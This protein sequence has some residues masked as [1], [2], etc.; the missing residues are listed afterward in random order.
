MGLL[1]GG[2]ALFDKTQ[3]KKDVL[4]QTSLLAMMEKSTDS[5]EFMANMDGYLK[6]KNKEQTAIGEQLA[7]Q[8]SRLNLSD[9]YLSELPVEQGISQIKNLG[10][11]LG[12]GAIAIAEQAASAYMDTQVM[13][14]RDVTL[15]ARWGNV[16]R[17]GG[18]AISIAGGALA[19]SIVPRL[20]TLV[21]AVGAGVVYV[22]KETVSY[23]KNNSQEKFEIEQSNKNAEITSLTL[24]TII[25]DGNRKSK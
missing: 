1:T 25:Y 17:V 15:S 6:N 5:K 3:K 22:G 11:A 21:G 8:K 23:F 13:K 4:S 20:G 7:S 16:K 10:S 18:L 12:A 14:Q 19:G 24:G 9:A 2:K